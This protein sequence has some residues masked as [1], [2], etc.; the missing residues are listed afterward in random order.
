MHDDAVLLF[1]AQHMGALPIYER[2]VERV[3]EEITEVR[4]KVQK[5]QISFYRRH[6]FAC[7]SFI[8]V[9]P[10]GL[11]PAD[12]L[13]VTIGLEHRLASERVD[14][15]TEPYPNRWTHHILLADPAEV[16]DELMGWVRAAAEFAAQK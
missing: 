16:D 12:Y 8:K 9:R 10:K 11:C 1:F 5:S 15:A 2:F 3:Q 13:V 7:L 6:M 4:I 14:V